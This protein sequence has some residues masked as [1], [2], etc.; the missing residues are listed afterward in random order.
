MKTKPQVV[1]QT[2]KVVSIN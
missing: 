1:F 2:V